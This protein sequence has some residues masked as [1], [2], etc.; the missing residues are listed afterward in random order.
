MRATGLDRREESGAWRYVDGAHQ[1]QE[2]RA[3]ALIELK[4][5]RDVP[6]WMIDVIREF[7]LVRQGYSKYE[8]SI[9]HHLESRSAVNEAFRRTIL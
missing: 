9:V 4:F 7:E 3:C 2:L 5:T 6:M 1:M 8:S